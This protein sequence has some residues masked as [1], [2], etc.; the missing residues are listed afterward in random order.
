[1]TDLIEAI[2]RSDLI[3]QDTL[4]SILKRK[5]LNIKKKL[6]CMARVCGVDIEKTLEGAVKKEDGWILDFEN[7]AMIHEAL[8]RAGE[9]Q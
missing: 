6:Q 7:R 2:E 1:M 3:D 8:L 9:N 5:D 4:W